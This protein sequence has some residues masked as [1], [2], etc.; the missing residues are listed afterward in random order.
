MNKYSVKQL[1]IYNFKVFKNIKPVIIKFENK[2]LSIL[3][4]PNGF[5]KTT[6]FDALEYALTGDIKRITDESQ[7][8]GNAAFEN[9]FLAYDPNDD[10]WVEVLLCNELS[11]SIKIVRKLI[12]GKGKENNPAR[13]VAN[14]NSI[15][16][17][18]EEVKE[19]STVKKANEFLSKYINENVRKFYHQYYYI[20]QENR[21]TFLMKS[22]TER[23]KKINYIF[24]MQKENDEKEKVDLIVSKF[25][26]LLTDLE[27]KKR[28]ITTD[29]ENVNLK[30][31]DDVKL[32]PYQ[33]LSA[34]TE[35]PI[36]DQEFPTILDQDVLAEL[37]KKVRARALFLRNYSFFEQDKRNKWIDQQIQDPSKIKKYLFLH[38][39]TQKEFFQD[40]DKYKELKDI[41]NKYQM[42]T[43]NADF[44]NFKYERVAELLKINYLGDE[45]EQLVL[46][47]KD[48]EI[49]MKAQDKARESLI[50]IRNNLMNQREEWL[51][52]NYSGIEAN[53]CPFCGQTW[54]SKEE[55][56]KQV[57]IVTEA[58]NA[59][60]NEIINKS[61]AAKKK[62][63]T[64]YTENFK[65][66]IDEYLLSSVY[67]E[68]DF[69]IEIALKKLQI[70][71]E[72]NSFLSDA[73]KYKIEIDK[74]LLSI[75]DMESW[76]KITDEFCTKILVKSKIDI[77]IHIRQ[78]IEMYDFGSIFEIEFSGD[79]GLVNSAFTISESVE[80]AKI[81]YL[82]QHY[83]SQ[84]AKRKEVL[85][86]RLKLTNEQIDRTN[87]IKSKYKDLE[88]RYT[89]AI[90]N[91]QNK[92][93]M[94]LQIPFYLFTG[95]ILQNYPGGLGVCLEVKGTKS[96][97]FDASNRRGHDIIYT[98]SSGQ[99]S[100]VSI[101]FLLT[102]NR[103]YAD[104]SFKCVFIDDPMQTM[105]EL[106]ITSF[107]DLLRNDFPEYQF[108]ISTH[109]KDFSD[110]IRYK[111][112]NY[113][114]TQQRIDVREIYS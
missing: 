3:D 41:T 82:D 66:T 17:F 98:M 77:P 55:L 111:F 36:W 40:A 4:G 103:I 94:Q 35:V 18:N 52:N 85:E 51:K 42:D 90:Q 48:C 95:R 81:N 34:E 63:R 7:I 21:L 96:I 100:A 39:S 16:S 71:D 45:I 107:V 113:Y 74:D 44:I 30:S 59:A 76:G 105:D 78:Y 25:S 23:M 1:R 43:E 29:L 58:I 110:Y 64:I 22:E 6:I 104:K 38:T 99:L 47:V 54:L 89:S 9:H 53:Q 91:Y 67:F 15:I 28:K 114:L 62:L 86:K 60:S 12:K 27:E 73:K 80:K 84:Q 69:I 88:Q 56:E 92:I 87:R 57:Q 8:N 70:I 46:E 11:E 109:E 102:M 13:L 108:I 72:L 50:F 10:V 19:F 14:T 79:S 101:G 26:K 97:H 93:V 106:N 75:E 32:I 5:G 112:D 33:K 37:Q 65:K 61:I 31:T 83:F 20:T 49:N 24:H 68:D 2:T